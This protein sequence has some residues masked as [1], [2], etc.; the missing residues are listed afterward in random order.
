M[1]S[2][3]AEI[4]DA[5]EL[6][7][8]FYDSCSRDWF[9]DEA[10]AQSVN[11]DSFWIMQT[12]VTNAQFAA[13]VDAGGYG[14]DQWWTE[15]GTAWRKK[16]AITE[17]RYWNDAAWN[18]SDYP[19]VG[20]SWYEAMAYAAWLADKT[21]LAIRLPT[22]AEWEKAARGT[23]G[24]VFPWGDTWDGTLL[25]YC[26]DNC[27]YGGKDEAVNDGSATTAPVGTYSGGASPYGAL[28][29]AGNVWEWTSSQYGAYPYDSTD[30]RED[31][32]GS[33]GRVLRGGSW[34]IDPNNVRATNRNRRDP[35]NRGDNVG[36]RLVLAVAPR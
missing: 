30:G 2:T 32:T 23:A 12:E 10:P 22:E 14:Q 27:T 29:M 28:D 6:C 34:P 35:V 1:G 9:T 26:D 18:Q 15:A 25:N 5:F 31:P 13:F 36:V 19:V 3:D 17:P 11:V 20:I 21:G 7:K 24:Y 33:A 16:N 4:D 8:R